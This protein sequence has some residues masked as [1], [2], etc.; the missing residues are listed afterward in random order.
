MMKPLT[1]SESYSI[2]IDIFNF[3]LFYSSAVILNVIYTRLYTLIRQ[4]TTTLF[5]KIY[6]E[7][8]VPLCVLWSELLWSLFY[9][10]Q[11]I[12]LL[13]CGSPNTFSE[14]VPSL[15]CKIYIRSTPLSS[16]VTF[17]PGFHHNDPRFSSRLSKKR[18]LVKKTRLQAKLAKL[19]PVRE[20]DWVVCA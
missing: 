9:I 3:C 16:K 8:K 10:I 20:D 17:P 18:I 5:V 14:N 11:Y 6:Y 12:F 15:V 13:L 4:T 1:P 19:S 2:M 7:V